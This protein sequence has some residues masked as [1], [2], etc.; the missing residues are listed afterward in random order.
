M[1]APDR[2]GEPMESFASALNRFLKITGHFAGMTPWFDE[3]VGLD[4][5][6]LRRWRNG[7]MLP[8]VRNWKHFEAKV[9]AEFKGNPGKLEALDALKVVWE[10]HHEFEGSARCSSDEDAID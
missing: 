4:S 6:Y 1:S 8:S 3:C 2:S 7:E 10:Y 5:R 9:R